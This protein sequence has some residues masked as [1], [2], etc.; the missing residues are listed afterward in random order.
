[1]C[2]KMTSKVVAVVSPTITALSIVRATN[3]FLVHSKSTPIAHLSCLV[4]TILMTL[5]LESSFQQQ[6]KTN[7]HQRCPPQNH[8]RRPFTFPEAGH[9]E[10][11][12]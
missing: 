5:I 6:P 11:Q 1:M 7:N 2:S 3:M 12:L 4:L 10:N 8:S 9:P